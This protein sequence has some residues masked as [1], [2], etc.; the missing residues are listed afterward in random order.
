MGY[1]QFMQYHGEEV[2]QAVVASV[3]FGVVVGDATMMHQRTPQEILPP[4]TIKL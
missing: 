3:I 4:V 2:L 1:F